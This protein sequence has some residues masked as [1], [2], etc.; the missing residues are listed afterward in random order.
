VVCMERV[1]QPP[2]ARRQGEGEEGQT[3]KRSTLRAHGVI[4]PNVLQNQRPRRDN[5]TGSEGAT[6]KEI[7]MSKDATAEKKSEQTEEKAPDPSVLHVNLPAAVQEKLGI[8]PDMVKAVGDQVAETARVTAYAA[9]TGIKQG[10][11]AS[12][13][14]KSLEYLDT[15][16]KGAATAIGAGSVYGL[17]LLG[18][19][20][21]N[22][23]FG[24][25]DIDS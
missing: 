23:I 8:T 6:D 14:E 19:M 13:K 1:E 3:V 4:I 9:V 22:A 17:F 20:G 15:G 10:A 25:E 11:R 2:P 7:A 24:G 18:R 21:I 16:F 5:N 12:F